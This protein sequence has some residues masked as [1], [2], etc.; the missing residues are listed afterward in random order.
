M[1]SAAAPV[2]VALV[3]APWPIFNRPSIQLAALRG[4][5]E[6]E[7]HFQVALH[8]PYLQVARTIGIELYGPIAQSG[9]AGEALFAALLFPEKQAEARRLF[10][11]SLAKAIRPRPDFDRLLAALQECLDHWR[12]GLDLEGCRLIGFSVCFHQLL[13]SLYLA[14]R[15]KTTCPDLP[16]VF[17]GSSCTGAAGVS[18]AENFAEIDFV[19]DGEGEEPLLALCRYLGGEHDRLPAQVHQARGEGKGQRLSALPLAQTEFSG[20][21]YPDYTPYIKEMTT[22]FAEQAFI[23]VLPVEFSRGCWWNRCT[24]CN[25]NLQWQDYRAKSA[26]RMAAEVF[27]L[28]ARHQ[29]LQFTFTDNALPPKEA[30]NFFREMAASGMDLDFFAEL[31][32]ITLPQRLRGYRDGGL[33]TV[34][35]GIEALSNSLLKKMGKGQT[36]MQ[37]VAMIK[38]CSEIGI[39]LEGNLLTDFPGTSE[40]EIETTLTNLDFLLPFKPLQTASF[41]L[42]LGSPIQCRPGDFSIKAVLPHRKN[43]QL[44]PASLLRSLTLLINGYRGDR[45]RQQKLWQPVRAKVKG[46][47]RFHQQRRGSRHSPLHFEDGRDFL[48]IRQELPEGSPLRHRLRGASRAIYLYC[49]RP[50]RIEAI[51]RHCPGVSERAL[52]DFLTMMHQKRLMFVEND[53]ALAL[54]IRRFC[55]R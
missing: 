15:I 33:H 54:A 7:G 42:G 21:P 11:K 25:L 29:S 30:E 8:H 55:F 17:G 53:L 4:F 36:V 48:L 9:W 19:I 38:M 45:F 3:A 24:F 27:T 2:R 41:F 18:L 32:A 12:E 43:R 51:L 39:E 44:F 13:A 23:P 16:V 37:C 40:K 52:R 35:V 26:T 20:L 31:R 6:R 47:E 5:L 50:R 14:R 10:G 34:Q 49:H 1:D 22:T 28:A 46:W